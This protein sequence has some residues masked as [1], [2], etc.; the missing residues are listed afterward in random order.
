[1]VRITFQ[2]RDFECAPGQSVLDCL[3]AGGMAIP[4]GCGAGACQTCLMR[5]VSGDV[6]PRAQAGLKATQAAQ[7]Y[8]LACQWQPTRDI[9]VGFGEPP[10]APVPARVLE[11]ESLSPDIRRL[12]LKPVAPFDYRAGQFLRLHRAGASRCYSLASVPA[13][14]EPLELHV[15][16]VPG[17]E[18]S[19]WV[20]ERLA[21]GDEV[22]ISSATGESFYLAGKPQQGLCLIGTGSGLAPLY[23]IARDALHQGHTGPIWL[24][25]GSV[26]VSGLY[27]R[28]QLTQL[29]LRYATFHYVP[30]VSGPTA[31]PGAAAA[32]LAQGLV[33]E[34]ALQR[35]PQFD[36]WS[37]HLCGNPAMVNAARRA[38]FLAGASMRDI[39]SDPFLPSAPHG[40]GQ[41][42]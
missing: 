7:G 9:E 3:N 5:A 25:H 24:F 35:L 27:L 28:E 4:W 11:V 14:N 8:F 42:A 31:D 12:R 6:D 23:G 13:L 2:S 1:M 15:R 22:A 17:G 30:C 38:T 10:A 37:V 18:I 19:G 40:A 20:H 16:H 39:H 21:P 29:A 32:G 36:G 34:V 41:P 26:E 33:H